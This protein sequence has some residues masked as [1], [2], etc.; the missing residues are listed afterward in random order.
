MAT[1]K[2]TVVEV[3]GQLNDQERGFE[4]TRWTR[5]TLI[6]YCNDA[7]IQ[8]A[9]YRPDAFT[10]LE[11]IS[12]SPGTQQMLPEKCNGLASVVSNG[13]KSNPLAVPKDDSG[14]IRS[15]NKKVCNYDIDCNGNIIYK[16]FSY[17]YD[18]RIPNV[19][20]VSPPVPMGINPPVKIKISCIGNPP[21]LTNSDWFN[22]LPVEGKYYNAIISWML[23]RAY[24]V[25]TESETSF[26]MLQY[27]RAEFY[28]MMGVKYQMES[29]F[30]SGWYLGQR[31]NE[32]TVKGNDS[33]VKD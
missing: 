10:S 16:I 20:Y 30:N 15:F 19:F 11:E 32:T 1:L 21:T 22:D 25:D 33:S 28:K 8:V 29:K 4:F 3:S 23:S 5:P 2:S 18:P 27:Q 14:L 9:L 31:G 13:D 6:G 24:E 26:R 7:L 17:S 12:L